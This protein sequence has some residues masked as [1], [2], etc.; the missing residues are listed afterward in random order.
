MIKT[1]YVVLEGGCVQNVLSTDE[2][3]RVVVIDHDEEGFIN[4][5]AI[6]EEEASN[7]I[8]KD[9]AINIPFELYGTDN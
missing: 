2:D 5:T 1:V 8:E 9:N 7:M 3:I 6:T 4:D